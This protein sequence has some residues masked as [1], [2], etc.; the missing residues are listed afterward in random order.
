MKSAPHGFPERKSRWKWR[1]ATGRSDYSDPAFY[2]SS[3]T[4][5]EVAVRY[6]YSPKTELG[7]IYQIGR[8]KVDGTGAAGHP[9]GDG[10][11]RLAAAREDPRES[12]GRRASTGSPT[13]VPTVNPVLEGRIDWKPRKGTEVFVTAYMREEASAFYAG[14]NYQRAAARRPGFPSASAGNG[15]P[16]WKA[17]TRGTPTSRFPEPARAGG[18]TASG[19][20]A[21]RWPAEFGEESDLSFFYRVSDNSSNDPAFGY[22]QQML[23]VELNHKF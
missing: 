18:T 23:G 11:H 13:T 7:L 9:A 1:R 12:R 5:G 14:Q 8:F 20:S 3:K 21:R 4:Y 6:T 10:Q 19:S 22:D 2:D 17:A 15:P 16:S